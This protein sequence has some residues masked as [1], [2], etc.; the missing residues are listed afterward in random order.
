MMTVIHVC[1]IV[2]NAICAV[3]SAFTGDIGGMLINGFLAAWLAI[4]L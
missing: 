2:G 3:V 4:L 1:L